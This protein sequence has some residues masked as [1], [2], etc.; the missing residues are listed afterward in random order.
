MLNPDLPLEA[1]ATQYQSRGRILVPDLFVP[2][3]ADDLHD[4]LAQRTEWSLVHNEADG[5]VSVLSGADLAAMPP[6]EKAHRLQGVLDRARDG[7]SFLYRANLMADRYLKGIEPEHPLNRVIEYINGPE[8]LGLVR[9]ITGISSITKADA[10][11]TLYGPGDFLT[12]HDDKIPAAKRRVAYVLGMSR[13]WRA[14]WGGLLQF[15][16]RNGSVEEV[17]VPRFNSLML[18]TVPQMHAVTAVAPYAP[19][20]RYSITG[21]FIDP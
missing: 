12:T 15:Y 17:F 14:D 16:D 21:W 4:I 18:F 20:A 10:Q 11:A 5:R 8:F 9:R 7:F 13:G 3:A 2:R 19:M 1:L 6:Q